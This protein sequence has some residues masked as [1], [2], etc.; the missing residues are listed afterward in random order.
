MLISSLISNTLRSVQALEDKLTPQE[1]ETILEAIRRARA[2]IAEGDL[3][4]LQ[5][6]LADMERAAAKIGA[7]MLRP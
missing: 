1:T 2:A 6:G 7:A 5:Q 4:D 3:I